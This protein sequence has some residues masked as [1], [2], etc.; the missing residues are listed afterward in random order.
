MYKSQKGTSELVLW[1]ISEF[2]ML[3]EECEKDRL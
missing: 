3:K 1:M 2:P